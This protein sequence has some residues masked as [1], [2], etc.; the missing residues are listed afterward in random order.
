MEAASSLNLNDLTKTISATFSFEELKDFCAGHRIKYENFH[1]N[2]KDSFVRDLVEFCERRD[3]L[4]ELIEAL[5]AERPDRDW[6]F[7]NG[8]S[9]NPGQEGVTKKLGLRLKP[10]EENV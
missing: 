8:S 2:R 3:K 9:V 10:D 7:I 5:E 1:P 4:G 6:R